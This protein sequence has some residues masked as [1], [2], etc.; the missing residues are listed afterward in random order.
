[1]QG[2]KISK[3]ILSKT[4]IPKSTPGIVPPSKSSWFVSNMVRMFTSVRVKKWLPPFV[5]E[6]EQSLYFWVIRVG[7]SWPKPQ[8]Y[9]S[10]VLPSRDT[11]EMER[12]MMAF[13]HKKDAIS[14]S[15][16]YMFKNHRIF[17]D[18]VSR[19]YLEKAAL[20]SMSVA[21]FDDDVTYLQPSFIIPKIDVDD[22][23]D[24]SSKITENLDICVQLPF[25][26]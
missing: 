4:I 20:N 12:Y 5:Y 23:S 21:V 11:G 8:V 26:K 19:E 18:H 25:Q 13:T 1:M 6:E 22:H 16:S 9:G 14:A 10:V 24:H 3:L 15:Q 17:I 2:E 7:R